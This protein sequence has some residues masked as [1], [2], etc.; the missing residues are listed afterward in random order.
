[1]GWF[2]RKLK[3]KILVAEFQD[4]RTIIVDA[5]QSPSRLLSLDIPLLN[6]GERETLEQALVPASSCLHALSYVL[7][8]PSVA[9][10]AEDIR[11]ILREH[12]P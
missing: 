7:R 4:N 12:L 8:P 3:C 6:V 11:P 1:M 5:V 10:L 9:S 2:V